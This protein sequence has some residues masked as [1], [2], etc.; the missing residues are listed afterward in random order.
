MFSEAVS[1]GRWLTNIL[2]GIGVAV[3]LAN[4]TRGNHLDDRYSQAATDQ[5][6]Y[7][8][9][10]V[11]RSESGAISHRANETQLWSVFYS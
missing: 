8:L 5:L 2:T 3:L 11:P 1:A 4:W 9:E 10:K 7:L 6:T